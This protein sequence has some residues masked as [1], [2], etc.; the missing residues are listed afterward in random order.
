M[1]GDLYNKY[2]EV[3]NE[4]VDLFVKKH[5]YDVLRRDFEDCW[6][7]SECGTIILIGDMFIDFEDIRYD[8]DNEV[9][10]DRFEKWY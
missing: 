7:A 10:E 2:K 6:V 8:I 3:C 4:Y 9:P 5:G 1:R